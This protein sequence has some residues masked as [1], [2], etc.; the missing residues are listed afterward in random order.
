MWQDTDVNRDEE[1]LSGD[2]PSPS[3]SKPTKLETEAD[4]HENS[5]FPKA[6]WRQNLIPTAGK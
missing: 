6:S 4:K 5:S 3:K 1:L 2:K